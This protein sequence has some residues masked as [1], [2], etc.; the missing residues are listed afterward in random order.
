MSALGQTRPMRPKLYAWECPQLSKSGHARVASI[1]PVS[2]KSG[3]MHR[4]K[5]D[6]FDH[7][8][9][10]NEQLVRDRDAERFGGLEVDHQLEFSR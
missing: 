7:L 10:G 9:G 5:S 2:A 4:N 6:L 8:V 3:L 1:C